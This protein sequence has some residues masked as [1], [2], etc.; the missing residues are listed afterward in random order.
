ML[1]HIFLYMTNIDKES[2]SM[3]I[4]H[5]NKISTHWNIFLAH[6]NKTSTYY[7]IESP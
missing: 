3:K 4:T 2:L 1:P 6:W 5:W 7:T